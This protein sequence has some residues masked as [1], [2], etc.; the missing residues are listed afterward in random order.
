[1]FNLAK[2]M[3]NGRKVG[4]LRGFVRSAAV[5]GVVVAGSCTGYIASVALGESG[6]PKYCDYA[7]LPPLPAGC[8]PPGYY[9]DGAVAY[10]CYPCSSNETTCE[11]AAQMQA[12]LAKAYPKCAGIS[13]NSQLNV[14]CSTCGD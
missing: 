14:S 11:T 10:F 9:A 1:M 2:S 13:I 6:N 12:T 7:V 8:T 3:K 4:K 5:L